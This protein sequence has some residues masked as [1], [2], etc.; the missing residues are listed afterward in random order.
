MNIVMREMRASGKSLLVW[1]LSM[2]A[3]V[4]MTFAEFSAYYKNPEMLAVIEAMPRAML[5]AFGMDDANLTTVSGYVSVTVP[6]INLTLGIY[7]LLL[8]NGIIAREERDRTAG[9]LMTLPVTRQRIITGKLLAALASSAVLLAVVVGSILIAVLPYQREEAF[10]D[11]MVLVTLAALI[12][13]LIFLSLGM[14]LAA[15]TRRHKLSAGIGVGV[16]FAL[17]LASIMATL[18]EAMSFLRYVTPFSYFEGTKILRNLRLD[19]IDL[20]LSTAFIVASI[21]ATYLVYERRDLYV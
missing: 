19:P 13:M 6:F 7:A 3:F 1:S 16:L 17:Y 18:T 12:L 8:G 21:A 14:L 10:P 4:V 15:L 9:F 20:G 5:E 2:A 11:F